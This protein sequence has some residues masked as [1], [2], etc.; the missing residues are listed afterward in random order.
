MYDGMPAA[1]GGLLP[2][3]V[4][5]ALPHVDGG[6]VVGSVIVFAKPLNDDGAPP[7]VRAF[8]DDHVS[9]HQVTVPLP[10]LRFPS[11]KTPRDGNANTIAVFESLDGL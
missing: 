6:L 10:A 8:S 1:G 7:P 4:V 9:A 5:H 2:P 11:V 3:D